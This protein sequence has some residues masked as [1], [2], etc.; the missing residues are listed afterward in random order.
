MNGY[1]C[2]C[3]IRAEYVETLGRI[4]TGLKAAIISVNRSATDIDK[5]PQFR[6]QALAVC[7]REAATKG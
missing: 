6:V 1:T 3:E 4:L 7:A 2:E 5:V